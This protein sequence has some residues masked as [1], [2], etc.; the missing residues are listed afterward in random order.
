MG[1]RLKVSAASRYLEEENNEIF[2]KIEFYPK[3]INFL[4]KNK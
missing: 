2:L 3:N 1:C 4:T